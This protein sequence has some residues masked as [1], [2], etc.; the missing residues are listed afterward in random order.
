MNLVAKE[1][2]AAQDPE[3]P[4]VLVLSE[5]AGAARELNAA[6]IVNPYDEADM[7]KAMGRGAVDGGGGAAGNAT[8][9]CWRVMRTNSL[10]AVAG[11]FLRP[12]CAAGSISLRFFDTTGSVCRGRATRARLL[13]PRRPDR[14]GKPGGARGLAMTTLHAL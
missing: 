1:Y 4:G 14:P 8:S 13:L 12:I 5:F 7:A 10:D 3:E 9:P 6:L 11:P 2:V